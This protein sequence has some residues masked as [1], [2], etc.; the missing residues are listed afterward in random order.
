MQSVDAPPGQPRVFETYKSL[1]EVFHND[2]SA[3]APLDMYDPPV[4]NPCQARTGYGDLTLGPFSKFSNLGQAG[5]GSLIGPLV[6]QNTTYVRYLTGFDNTAFRQ[7]LGRQWYL[8]S[9]LPVPPQSVTFDNGSVTVKSAWVVM[10]GI[11]RPDRFY[12]RKARVL[13]S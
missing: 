8:R 2:G 6:A 10:T 1:D 9:K 13:P 12:T 4:Y 7:I 11:A 5:F 3:P